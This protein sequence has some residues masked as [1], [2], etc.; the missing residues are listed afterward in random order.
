MH[1]SSSTLICKQHF[2]GLSMTFQHLATYQGGARVVILLALVVLKTLYLNVFTNQT[3][4]ALWVIVVLP[5]KGHLL[6]LQGRRE[7]MSF[8]ELGKQFIEIH[9][10]EREVSS[11]NC[12]IGKIT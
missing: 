11:L 6:H 10:G 8:L 7:S 4:N 2:C 1:P 5:R 9:N 12:L 3:N